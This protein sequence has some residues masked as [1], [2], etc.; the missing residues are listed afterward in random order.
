MTSVPA[1]HD[2]KTA[3]IERARELGFD[4]CRIA[5]AEATLHAPELQEWLADGAAGEMNWIERGAAKRSDPE[6]VL[7]GA[8][9][10][11]VLALNYW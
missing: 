7:A 10:V 11:V 9:S 1:P 8:R 2:L 3:L 6:L 4:D 5:S